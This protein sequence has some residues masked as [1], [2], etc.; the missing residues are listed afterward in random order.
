MLVLSRKEDESVIIG[1]NIEVRVLE[2]RGDT[3]KLGFAAPREVEIDRSEVRERK[4]T[5]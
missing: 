2:V 3:V 5:S 4:E 1:A